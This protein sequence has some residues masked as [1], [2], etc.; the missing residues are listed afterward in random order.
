[1]PWLALGTCGDSSDVPT[2]PDPPTPPSPP[3]TPVI[4]SL[5]LSPYKDVGINL[6]WNT[7][8]LTTAVTGT[9][10]PLISVLPEKLPTV[11]LAFA[12]GTCGAESWAGIGGPALAQANI[13]SFIDA[14]KTYI[15]STGGA[16][17]SFTCT[18]DDSFATFIRTYYS[19]N[20]LGVDFDIEGGQSQ[21]DI[22]ALVQRVKV[23]QTTY[24]ALH[25]S[26]TVATLGSATSPNLSGND[27]GVAVLN[28]I[29]AAGLTNYTINL[30]VMDY[31]SS[32]ASNCVLN[33]TNR[34][35]MGL[36]AIAAANSLHNSFGVPY[37][38]IELTPMIGGND[39]IDEVFTLADVATIT[40]FAQQVGL[41]GLHY[42]SLDRDNDCAPGYA[43]P[44]CN[45]YGAAGTL[46]Y[47]NA[48]ISGL[49]F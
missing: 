49:G 11:T 26:F 7:D 15:I 6:N 23:A 31:G 32:I 45:S 16:Q 21:A 38:Q 3:P 4:T 28:A 35:D 42:W 48:F 13:Q 41:A 24:P 27:V 12:T 37:N 22:A 43:S 8:V 18:S 47:T 2:P 5:V 40:A 20:M 36:S 33:A 30:M 19:A 17:G 39:T 25:F 10:T 34:C 44:T 29:N 46:G 1:M 9:L 14:G